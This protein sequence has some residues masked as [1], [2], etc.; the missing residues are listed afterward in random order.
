MANFVVNNLN[1]SGAGSLRAAIEAA[2]NSTDA[3][4][5]ISFS[6]AGTIRLA[7]AYP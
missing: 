3:S 2:N 5:S 4:N 6:V 1:D 7:S